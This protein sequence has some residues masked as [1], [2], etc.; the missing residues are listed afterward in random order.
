MDCVDCI[1]RPFATNPI[2]QTHNQY[3]SDGAS[4]YLPYNWAMQ[5]SWKH[6]GYMGWNPYTHN[7]TSLPENTML[8]P[9]DWHHWLFALLPFWTA[10]DLEI[11]MQFFIAG[12]GMI[13]LVKRSSLPISCA[14]LAA[15]GFSFFSQF[16]MWM[17]DRWFGGMIWAPW[18]VWAFMR[19]KEKKRSVEHSG[20][21]VHLLGF[22]GRES[23]DMHLR[24]SL[25][26]MPFLGRVVGNKESLL[27]ESYYLFCISLPR[28]RF[29]GGIAFFR[30]ICRYAAAHAGMQN[31]PI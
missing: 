1:F 11:I 23:S 5:Q 29:A 9:G 8:S 10:W 19:R 6:D 15:V 24:R 26:G 21:S 13:I 31:T 20:C 30:C 12:L 7:G 2:E 22:S 4:Q 28:F 16:I 3:N 18:I 14:L 25:G 17:Y 27:M